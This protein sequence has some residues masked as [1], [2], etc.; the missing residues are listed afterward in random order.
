MIDSG[1]AQEQI[2]LPKQIAKEMIRRETPQGEIASLVRVL[3]DLETVSEEKLTKMPKAR[4]GCLRLADRKIHRPKL[5][6]VEYEMKVQ[7]EKPSAKTN[8]VSTKV[9]PIAKMKRNLTR[10]ANCA[11]LNK[12]KYQT[13]LTEE[14]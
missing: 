5:S 7:E 1:I 11:K 3:A 6:E 14:S 4:I 2:P 9:D 12:Q 8:E 13:A 10:I